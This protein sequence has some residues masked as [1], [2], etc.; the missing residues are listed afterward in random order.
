MSDPI[1]QIR[2]REQAATPGPW[3]WRGNTDHPISIRLGSS[4]GWHDV[5]GLIR[6]EVTRD[7]ARRGGVSDPD[8]LTVKAGAV[9]A[10]PAE[11]YGERWDA[12]VTAAQEEAITEYL[13]GPYGEPLTEIRLAFVTDGMYRAAQTFAVYEVCRDATDRNDPRVYRADIADLSH[14]D[15]QFI[16]HAREDV[17]VLLAEVDRLRTALTEDGD[18]WLAE[19][20]DDELGAF[21][22]SLPPAR[23]TQTVELGYPAARTEVSS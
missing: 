21:V 14:P 2:Q 23:P 20:S 1:E 4:S 15:A 9:P 3:G 22:S 6:D 13:T 19:A 7:E 10:E 17:R 16:A 5:I 8:S 18:D 12:A 11:T